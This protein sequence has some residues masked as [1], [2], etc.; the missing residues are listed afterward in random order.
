[1]L[2]LSWGRIERLTRRFP[3]LAFRLFRNLTAI[4]GQ[5]LRQTA[6]YRG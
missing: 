6:E 3:L 5:R 1:L 2:V 4:I